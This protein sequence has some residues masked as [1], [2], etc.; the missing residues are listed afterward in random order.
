MSHV[1]TTVVTVSST[2]E[3][4]N[5]MMKDVKSVKEQFIHH[6]KNTLTEKKE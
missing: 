5:H 1:V 2:T 3:L 6:R 4:I